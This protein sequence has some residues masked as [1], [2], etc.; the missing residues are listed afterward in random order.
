M[1]HRPDIRWRK[2]GQ[3]IKELVAIQKHI[4]SRAAQYV[5]PGGLL[6][7]TTCTLTKWENEEVAQWF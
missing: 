6:L 4:L 1:R 5:A 2:S 3:E 7:Y